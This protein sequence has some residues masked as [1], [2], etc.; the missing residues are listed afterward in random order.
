MPTENTNH[1]PRVDRLPPALPRPTVL[2]IQ[3]TMRLVDAPVRSIYRVLL[4]GW[5]AAGGV[6]QCNR[7]G[8]IYLK[9]ASRTQP[10]GPLGFNLAVLAG[11]ER[12]RGPAIDVAWDLAAGPSAYLPGAHD[13]VAAFE[14]AVRALPG[15]AQEGVLHRLHIGQSFQEEHARLLL[16]ALLAL[17][18]AA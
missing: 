11:P 1:T 15:Y 6:V 9:L 17:K 8:R 7:P 10:A 18:A 4:D 13:A 2:A 12:R 3:E 16:A 5:L 14:S